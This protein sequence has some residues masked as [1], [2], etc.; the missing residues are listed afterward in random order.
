ML[1]LLVVVALILTII[2]LFQNPGNLVTI[3]VLL[4]ELYLLAP[5]LGKHF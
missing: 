2:A 3:S 4:V 5:E 1:I